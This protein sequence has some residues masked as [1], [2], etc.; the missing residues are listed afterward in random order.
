MRIHHRKKRPKGEF[1]TVSIVLKRNLYTARY[2]VQYIDKGDM[3]L[4]WFSIKDVT[5]T[6]RRLEKDRLKMGQVPDR[7]RSGKWMSN[8]SKYY[9]ALKRGDWVLSRFGFSVTLDAPPNSDCQF[10]TA[11][12]QHA[13]F[14]KIVDRVSVPSSKST[15]TDIFDNVCTSGHDLKELL[16]HRFFNCMAKNLVEGVDEQGERTGQ[17]DKHCKI[18]KLQSDAPSQ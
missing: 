9:T 11:P 3:Q 15:S 2:K 14:V 4:K 12:H 8:R 10:L 1:V 5:S 7:P 13:L 18:A 17:T 16:V 6:T